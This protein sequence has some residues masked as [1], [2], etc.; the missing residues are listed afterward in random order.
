[1]GQTLLCVLPEELVL[2]GQLPTVLLCR[3]E[4]LLHLVVVDVVTDA[5]VSLD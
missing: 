1:M 3:V 2:C 5:E 4:L